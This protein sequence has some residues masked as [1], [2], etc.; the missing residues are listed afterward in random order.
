MSKIFIGLALFMALTVGV[1]VFSGGPIYAQAFETQLPTDHLRSM[2]YVLWHAVTVILCLLV[3]AYWRLATRPN[4]DLASF[5][6]AFQVGWGLLFLYA[7]WQWLGTVWI[8]PQWIIF[9]GVPLIAEFA[10]RRHPSRA[11]LASAA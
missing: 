6:S 5:T 9:L 2:A 8:M 11:P 1:H 3:L 10:L 4:R 7:G